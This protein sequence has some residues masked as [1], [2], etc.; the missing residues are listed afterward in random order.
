MKIQIRIA[1]EMAAEGKTISEIA[2]A[3]GYSHQGALHILNKHKIPHVK[4]RR[5][6]KPKFPPDM[7]KRS[8]RWAYLC[9][10]NAEIRAAYE[11]GEEMENIGK[12]FSITRERVR[13]IIQNLGLPSRREIYHAKETALAQRISELAKTM[14]GMGNIA[15]DIGISVHQ[16]KFIAR[17]FGI[18]IKRPIFVNERQEQ[19][20]QAIAMVANGASIRASCIALGLNNTVMNIVGNECQK[21]GIE[22]MHGRWRFKKSES[23][24][25]K[26]GRSFEYLQD[27]RS[28]RE[29]CVE[30]RGKYTAS[31]ISAALGVSRNA[32][33]G[34]WFRARRSGAI[35]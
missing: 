21:R 9:N 19:I 4:E 33:I 18:K 15:A 32:V 8:D 13:Q 35:S 1:S 31:E 22:L 6:P 30:M 2:E 27:G 5:G 3:I 17:R 7:D 25:Q 12:R 34:H 23:D 28:V 29:V 11:A 14:C 16:V 24:K 26:P 10:R 20:E